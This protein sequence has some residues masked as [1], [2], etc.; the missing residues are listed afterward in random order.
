MTASMVTATATPTP[1]RALGVPSVVTMRVER[2]IARWQPLVRAFACLPHLVWTGVLQIASVAVSFVIAG[3]VLVSGRVPVRLG[4]F[5]VLC[6]RER[7]RCYSYFFLL[8]TSAPPLATEVC[9]T[10]P[11][12]DPM[13]I[14]SA[15]PPVVTDR[16]SVVRRPLTLL[17]HLVVLLPLGLFLD[18]LYPVWMGTL[19]VRRR[20]PDNLLRLVLEVERWVG[21]VVLYV[22]Y[23]SDERPAFGLAAYRTPTDP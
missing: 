12:D 22:T 3:A 21:A 2:D 8:R 13:V 20:W 6:L 19:V 4:A 9:I 10:D 1:T 5:Q 14:V 15:S 11:G 23:A 16:R 17:G 18:V 7:V